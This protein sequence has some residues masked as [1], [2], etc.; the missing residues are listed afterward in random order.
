MLGL[1]A[2][3]LA[4]AA[5]QPLRA[6]G[7]TPIGGELKLSVPLSLTSIDPHD[8]GDPLAA[9]FAPLLFDTLVIHDKRGFT[10]GLLE[11]L[12]E[13]EAGATMMRLRPGLF[14]ARG[15]A[16]FAV[17]VLASLRRARAR[18]AGPLLDPLGDP[19][20]HPKDPR[21]LFF[22]NATPNALVRAL[23]SPLTALVPRD[24]DP[25]RPDGTGAMRAT[26]G[27]RTLT[28]QRN[29]QAALGPSFLATIAL[30]EAPSLRESLRDFEVAR[31]DLGWLGTGL[32]GGRTGVSSFDFGAVAQIVLVASSSAGSLARAGALQRLVDDIPRQ[33]LSHL[34]LGALPA[35]SS[36]ASYDGSPIDLWVEP[37]PH[38]LEIAQAVAESLSKSGHEISVRKASRAEIERKRAR[39]SVLSLAIARPIGSVA[40]GLAWLED[41]ARAASFL[42]AEKAGAPRQVGRELRVAVLG[43]LRVA[44][45]KIDALKLVA[46]ERGGWDLGA[47]SI[48]KR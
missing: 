46:A 17:D 38:W 14:S 40:A 47:S 29:E 12:P 3:A 8:A 4:A 20:P 19:K 15:R 24:F 6:L 13:R 44:G 30:S 5:P 10:P 36:S 18:G 43:E 9:L 48:R 25:Q 34:G 26:F 7:R 42:K 11:A 39:E 28:L 16:L 21:A 23:S 37:S 41:P 1:T 2:L 31:T 22:T 32:F 27:A 35:G 45:G 33:A